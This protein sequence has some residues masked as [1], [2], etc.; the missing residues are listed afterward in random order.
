MWWLTMKDYMTVEIK[1]SSLEKINRM[2]GKD[3][4]VAD[5][6][7]S[8]LNAVEGVHIDDVVEVKRDSVAILLKYASFD[9]NGKKEYGITFQELKLG[10]VGDK[11]Y[12][13]PNPGNG[14]YMNDMAEILFVD[15]RSVLVRVT[16]MLKTENN[17]NSIVHL[18]HVDLF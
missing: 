10:K 17:E 4:S 9:D 6:I 8:L 1:K 15:D 3:D 7:E 16:E 11:F 12:A 2:K 5:V 14:T 18:E 13:N